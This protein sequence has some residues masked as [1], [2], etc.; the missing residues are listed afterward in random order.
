MPYTSLSNVSSHTLARNIFVGM[1]LGVILGLIVHELPQPEM[2]WAHTYITQG[3]LSLGALLFITSI[4]IIVVPM[5]AVSLMYAMTRLGRGRHIGRL[6]FKTISLYLFTSLLAIGLAMFFATVFKLGMGLE[7]PT[8]LLQEKPLGPTLEQWVTQFIPKS[9]LDML[10]GRQLISLIAVSLIVGFAI[11]YMGKVGAQLAQKIEKLNEIILHILM[12]MIRF[13]PF[14][15]FCLTAQ[16]F[17][18][19][20]VG[21][22]GIL[23][24]YMLVMLFVLFLHVALTSTLLLRMMAGLKIKLFFQKMST[25]MLMAFSTTSSNM[26]LPVS[27]ETVHKKLGVSKP[28]ASFAM[29]LGAT[30]NMDGG[31]VLQGMATIF[32]ANYYGVDF[33]ALD[34]LM[35]VLAALIATIGTAGVPSVGP[36]ML[37]FVLQWVGLPLEGV[38]LILG[39]D[40]FLE[41]FRTTVNITGDAMVACV[42]AKSEQELDLAVYNAPARE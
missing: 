38:G 13:T 42:V 41:M 7:I 10:M 14:G 32:I 26:A 37:V 2:A 12:V 23:V 30:L 1:V 9:V 33:S 11:N 20:G 4:K 17:A 40:K 18:Y 5:I 22:V 15:V 39:V 21:M 31:A 29:P 6:G 34:Y 28:L 24:K 35:V 16:S 8:E 25:A 36:V 3:I 27:I 19:S